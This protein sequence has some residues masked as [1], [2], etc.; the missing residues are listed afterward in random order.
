MGQSHLNNLKVISHPDGDLF[1]ILSKDSFNFSNFGEA[2]FSTVNYKKVKGWKLHKKMLLNIVVPVGEIKFVIIENSQ[3]SSFSYFEYVLSKDNYKL[4]TIQP[5]S[6]FAFQGLGKSTN[7]LLN[8]SNIIHD[9]NEVEK[10][11]LDKF[12]YDWEL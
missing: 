4:L 6:Y 5:N 10:Y 2:Y 9:D 8:I 3:N 11:P 7:L 12:I 1:K